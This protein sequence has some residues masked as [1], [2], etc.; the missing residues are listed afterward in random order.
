[1]PA[2]PLDDPRLTLVGLLLESAWGLQRA[3]DRRLAPDGVTNQGL[4]LLLRLA[5]TGG[6]LRMS[7]LAAQA[8]L[9]PSGLTRAVD[10]LVDSGLVERHSCDTDRRGSF[11]A[12]TPR[13]ARLVRE[14][15]VAHLADID[16]TVGTALDRKEQR[17]LSAL[18]R[19]L[20]DN[21]HP[22]ATQRSLSGGC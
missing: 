18:L 21:V 14:A 2:D 17:Q 16:A 11:A 22:T 5:R 20:R 3:F 15:V 8:T 1:M 13:G 10:R 7:D 6:P 9:T 19:K 12:I 4:E